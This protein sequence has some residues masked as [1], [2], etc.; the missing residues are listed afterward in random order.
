MATPFKRSALTL[1][2][3][4]LAASALFSTGAQAEGK[5][6]I[7]QQFGIGYLIL[8]VVRDQNLIENTVKNRA[9]TSRSTGTAFPVPRR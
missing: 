8:D 1:L 5:I 4:S 6:S 7:A 3:T 2:A 9:S